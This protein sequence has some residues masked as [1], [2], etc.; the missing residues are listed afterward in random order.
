M[1]WDCLIDWNDAVAAEQVVARPNV[2]WMIEG[3]RVNV[4]VWRVFEIVKDV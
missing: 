2:L 1:L 3:T 4:N